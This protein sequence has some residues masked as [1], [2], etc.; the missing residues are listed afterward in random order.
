MKNLLFNGFIF[1]LGLLGGVHAQGNEKFYLNDL[2]KYIAQNDYVQYFDLIIKFQDSVHQSGDTALL[3]FLVNQLRQGFEELSDEEKKLLRK[4]AMMVGQEII[5]LTGNF[6]VGLEMYLIAH[7]N[8]Q[9]LKTLDPLAWFIENRILNIYSRKNEYE[10]AEYFSNLV[11][12]SLRHH[13]MHENLSRFYAN[14]GI[15]L[16]SEFKIAQADEV[17]KKGYYLADSIQFLSGVYAN[18]FNLASLYNE[19]PEL[20]PAEKY[21]IIAEDILDSL[22]SD[23]KLPEKWAALKMERAK[24]LGKQN[25]YN[26][27]IF[28][29]SEAIDTLKNYYKTTNRRE[30]AKHYTAFAEIFLKMDSLHHADS[31]LRLGLSSLIPEF[32]ISDIFPL[33]YQLYAENSFIDL[34]GTWSRV[35]Q[36]KYKLSPQTEY[37]E[38]AL[39]YLE[40]AL[41][42]NDLVRESVIADPSKLVAIRSNKSLIEESVV[43]LYDLYQIN[44]DVAYFDRIRSLFNRSKSLLYNEKTIRNSLLGRFT[45]AD[46]EK[47]SYMQA[48]ILRLQDDKQVNP[49]E[50]NFING[51]ILRCQEKLDEI[52]SHYDHIQVTE[53]TPENY[54]EYLVTDEKVYAIYTLNN[55]DGFVELGDYKKFEELASR[56]NEFILLKGQSMDTDIL[57]EMYDYLLSPL[58]S[59]IPNQLIIIPD[60][61]I[62]YVPFELLKVNQDDYLINLTTISYLFE[63]ISYN[64]ENAGQ[65]NELQIYCLHPQYSLRSGGTNTISRGSLYHLPY[66]K[67]EA[68]SI[69]S[70]FTGNILSSNAADKQD[71]LNNISKAGIFHYAGHAIIKNDSAFLVLMDSNQIASKL[72]EKEI[73]LLHYTLDMVVLSA[74]ET[75]LGK[76]EHGEGIRSLGRSFM[77]SGAKSTVISLWNVNDESTARIMTDFYKYLSKGKKKNEALRLAKLDYIKKSIKGKS[78]PYFWAAFIPAGDMSVIKIRI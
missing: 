2:P 61:D 33:P 30:F 17:F 78:H 46:K 58:P 1:F 38:K 31:V 32:G 22:T 74:C 70:L 72:T 23:S 36:Q 64:Y 35:Y 57:R 51:E 49:S 10:K 34:F 14:K 60:G 41:H 7:K 11:E 56:L 24:Y 63:Y 76:M 47:W 67:M 59:D 55:K 5:S 12:A 29:F 54:I 53:T 68:D 71:C 8:V 3:Y 43:I 15:K 26:E 48:K 39:K 6:D 18:A 44:N 28:L 42:V 9:N 73:G 75:G 69:C 66:A 16:K 62:G 4:A 77:E 40:V 65:I 20:G 50:I 37:L 52:F 19:Y 25:Q 13:K 45:P 27:S 21:L